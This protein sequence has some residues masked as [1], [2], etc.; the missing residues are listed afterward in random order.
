M[1]IN[2]NGYFSLSF[3]KNG[4][5]QFLPICADNGIEIKMNEHSSFWVFVDLDDNDFRLLGFQDKSWF[6]DWLKAQPGKE[7]I[8]IIQSQGRVG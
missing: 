4:I 5:F 7:K 3:G 1:K 8:K 6:D 2:L